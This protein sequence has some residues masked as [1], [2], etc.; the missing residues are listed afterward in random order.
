MLIKLRCKNPVCKYNYEI[1]EAELIDNG[2]L[3]RFCLM[4]GGENEIL[5]LEEIVD[6]DIERQVRDNIN[7]WFKSEG[8][9]RTIEIC[10]KHKS[11]AIYRLYQ[12]EL[13]K[14]GFN[15]P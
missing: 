6:T 3:H 11:S 10:E 2:E 1:T 14:R 12:A 9:E 7:K 4:C 13:K 15:I 5:N 8:I